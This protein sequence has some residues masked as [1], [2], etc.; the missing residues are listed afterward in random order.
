MRLDSSDRVWVCD[1]QNRRIQI[2]DVDGCFLDEWTAARRPDNIFID[3]REN[4]L[5]LTEIEK[6][7][8]IYTLDG[9]LIT[10][11]SGVEAKGVRSRVSS[12]AGHMAF[13][14]TRAAICM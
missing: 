13:G 10:Q 1:R 5:Y 3:P 14:W 7:V 8:S 9:E 6:Q 12:W 2:F 11:W 4:V